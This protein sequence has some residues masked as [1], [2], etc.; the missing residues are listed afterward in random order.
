MNF[1]NNS[2]I[3]ISVFFTVTFSSFI[4]ATTYRNRHRANDVIN[5]TGH[6]TR[7]F[8]SDLVTWSGTYNRIAMDLKSS[9]K[10]LSQDREEVSKF[11]QSFGIKAEDLKFSAVNVTKENETLYD[12]NSIPRV[13]FKGFRLTQSVS[14]QSLEIN[15][16][17]EL[18]RQVTQLLNLGIELN[19]SAPQ[20]FYTK[21][22]ELKLAMIAE[23][24]RDGRA[25]AEKISQESGSKL[26][27]LRYAS[28]G[29]FQ[30]TAENSDSDYSWGGTFDTSS[31]KKNASITTKLQFGVE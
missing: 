8:D 13:N 16:I 17:E 22:P 30:I 14:I 3:A 2:V 10:L 11:L 20:Y 26:G 12:K 27:K 29:V 24:T 15:K 19:S 9:Y 25:R 18:S 7:S 23:A 28:M 6:G 31:R 4:V 21:M 5:V 1:P